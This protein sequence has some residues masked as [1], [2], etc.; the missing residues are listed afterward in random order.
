MAR[1][2]FDQLARAAE[3]FGEAPFLIIGR[4]EEQLSFAALHAQAEQFGVMLHGLGVRPGDRVGLWMTNQTSWAVAAY[5]IARVGAVL[6]GLNTRLAPREIAHMLTLT[7]PRVVLMEESFLGK[8]RAIDHLPPVREALEREG[9]AAPLFVVRSRT[10]TRHPDTLD[11][12][13]A[14]TD[15][16][17]ADLAPSPLAPAA[18]LVACIDVPGYPELRGAA[19]ILSTSGTT[20]KPKGVVLG[21][22]NLVHLAEEVAKRQMLTPQD[23]FYSVGPM[24]HCSGYMHGLLTNL[25]A[26]SR[27]YTT[28]AYQAEESWDVFSREGITAYHGFVIPL[29][30]MARLPQ[31]DRAKLVLDRAWYGSPAAEMA[32]LETVYGARQCELFGMTETGGNTSLCWPSDPVVMRHDSD[33]RPH[34]GV[35]VKITDPTTGVELPHGSAGEICIRGWNVMLGYF[36][37]PAA[38]AKSFDADGFFH[39]GD[40]GM[41]LDDGFIRWMSR[42]K[43][44]IRVGGENLS[45]L[46]VEEVLMGHPA[47]QGAAVVAVPHPRL[48]EVPVAFLIPRPGTRASETEL[49]DFCSGLLANFKVPR[50]FVFVP[51]FPRTDATM[52]VQKAKLRDMALELDV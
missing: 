31:F 17:Q 29:Q 39:T 14:L 41:Q 34:D 50:R 43:D 1:T 35:D 44:M 10:G 4:G 51:D 38:T 33:G 21:H 42:L 48:Q 24:F 46:E 15:A 26:G 20:G 52:R 11:W 23:R 27:Y 16:S 12:D 6:V 7:R 37:D 5:G 9:A 25:I 32:R 28:P 22:E 2:L 3:R 45:P 36:A 19:A 13:Q 40:M 30:E 18:D 49:R 47:V 8:V